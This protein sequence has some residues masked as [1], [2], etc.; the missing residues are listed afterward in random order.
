MS[1]DYVWRYDI[2]T[3]QFHIQDDSDMD[4]TE[5]EHY[6]AVCGLTGQGHFGTGDF[7][8]CQLCLTLAA[9]DVVWV[10]DDARKA[11]HPP[12][13]RDESNRRIER[14]TT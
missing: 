11:Q 14:E 4:V 8:R 7:R 6:G 1:D 13:T 10:A 2:E 9:G 3:D 12:I 5:L